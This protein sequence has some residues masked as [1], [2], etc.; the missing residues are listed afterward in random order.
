MEI[1]RKLGFLTVILISL[2]LWCCRANNQEVTGPPNILFI[3]GDDHTTQAISSYGGILADYADT[4]HIDRLANEGVRFTN[5]FCSNAI[6]SP[7]R[8]TLLT[9]KYS[10]KNG[11]RMLGE[12]FDGSQPTVQSIVRSAGYQTAIFGKWH[13]RS[14]PTGFDEYKVL[15]VQGRYQDPE[16]HVSDRDSFQCGQ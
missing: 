14:R 5:V 2:G 4:R 12:E 10:H 13:L 9:G 16:F 3:M 8:A 6:C 15:P 7:S 1:N 11:I